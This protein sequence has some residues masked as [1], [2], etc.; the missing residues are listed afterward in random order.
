M[1]SVYILQS[2]YDIS[3]GDE[4]WI[5]SSINKKW[6]NQKCNLKKQYFDSDKDLVRPLDE[7]DAVRVLPD[8]W[9]NLVAYWKKDEVKVYFSFLL[10]L[11]LFIMIV[12]IRIMN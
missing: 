12:Y 11:H 9:I 6:R 2:R 5:L 3:L 7:N 1:V 8:Q 10:D 4:D